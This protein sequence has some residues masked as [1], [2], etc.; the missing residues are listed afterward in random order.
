M[1]GWRQTP[2]SWKSFKIKIESRNWESRKQ[3]RQPPTK[4]ILNRLSAL[5]H[6][7]GNKLAAMGED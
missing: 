4:M 3:K 6:A 2:G 1:R 5:I 7:D